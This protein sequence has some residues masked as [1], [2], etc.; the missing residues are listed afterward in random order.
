MIVNSKDLLKSILD[1]V[2]PQEPEGSGRWRADCPVHGGH[3]LSVQQ[4]ASGMVFV[5]CWAGCKPD[6]V[7]ERLGLN[8]VWMDDRQFGVAGPWAAE[9]VPRANAVTMAGLAEAKGLPGAGWLDQYNCRQTESGV[10]MEYRDQNHDLRAV[11]YRFA[12][13][14][15]QG[16]AWRKGDRPIPYGLWHLPGWQRLE[17]GSLGI[18]LPRLGRVVFVEGESD[19]WT[20]WY[21]GFAALGIPGATSHGCLEHAH[22]MQFKEAFVWCE[23]DRAGQSFAAGMIR[24]LKELGFAGPVKVLCHERHKDPNEWWQAERDRYRFQDAFRAAMDNAV[25]AERFCL[26]PAEKLTQRKVASQVLARHP[27]ELLWHREHQSWMAWDGARYR[28]GRR[29]LARLLVGRHLEELRAEAQKEQNP[30]RRRAMLANV[31]AMESSGQANGV[32]DLMADRL[33]VSAEDL[34]ADP[35]LLNVANGMVDLRTGELLPHDRGQHCTRLAPVAYD[36][37]ADGPLWDGA[38]RLWFGGDEDLADYVR[39]AVGASLFGLPAKYVFFAYGLGDNGKSVFLKTV[40]AVAGDYAGVVDPKVV[41]A[42]R[43]AA[44]PAEVA[45]LAGRRLVLTSETSE[46][47]RFD[48]ALIKRW[49]GGVPVTAHRKFGHPFSFLPA[50]KLW[51]EGNHRPVLRGDDG[52]VWNRLRVVPFDARIEG[53]AKDTQFSRRLIAEYPAVLRWAVS[54]AVD[55]WEAGCDV[56]EEPECVRLAT[57]SYQR[58]M[59]TVGCF[60]EDEV[61]FTDGERVARSEMYRA[62]QSWCEQNGF[63]P[64]NAIEFG[65]KLSRKDVAADPGRRW[66]LGVELAGRLK[67]S[68]AEVGRRFCR[69]G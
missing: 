31:E 64:T 42:R 11:R 25:P 2:G 13:K 68:L 1:K 29:D 15:S 32:L 23:P 4:A 57:E 63:E 52:G 3:S 5:G 22:V 51:I 61:V 6:A 54:G 33:A 20:L 17:K 39:R 26:D 24:R 45:E 62:Y 60:V 44:H 58:D 38:V 34:D 56:G 69:A 59:D 48:A 40:A 36:P 30:G 49:T 46:G 53:K 66:W 37:D 9:V 12:Y 41:E 67:G 65:R 7:A 18:P 43:D 16:S 55:W 28:D 21:A 50:F 10:A 19:C 8:P 27:G 35:H 47:K 14:A